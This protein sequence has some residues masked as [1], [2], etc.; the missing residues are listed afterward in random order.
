MNAQH[1][2]E[3]LWW[4][5]MVV[6]G[7]GLTVTGPRYIHLIDKGFADKSRKNPE[8]AAKQVKTTR[9]LGALLGCCGLGL[10]VIALLKAHH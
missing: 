10:I 2:G 6:A 5:F 4:I 7:F 1:F 8:A 9:I 3:L